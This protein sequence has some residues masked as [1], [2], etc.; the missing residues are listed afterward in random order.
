MRDEAGTVL[1]PVVDTRRRRR[2]D[3]VLATRA[4]ERL[5]LVHLSTEVAR[6]VVVLV[7]RLGAGGLCFDVAGRTRALRVGDLVLD[8]LGGEFLLLGRELRAL[9]C[10]LGAR[11]LLAD[12]A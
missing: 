3:D 6:Y 1:T 10:R 4:C 7:A 8:R 12:F 11:R 9:L 5:A 2:R